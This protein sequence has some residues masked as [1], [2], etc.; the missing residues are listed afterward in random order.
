MAKREPLISSFHLQ[1]DIPLSHFGQTGFIIREKVGKKRKCLL[2]STLS[3][4]L[5]WKVQFNS[6]NVNS[7][8]SH[9][10]KCLKVT[11]LLLSICSQDSVLSTVL[12][13]SQTSQIMSRSTNAYLPQSSP[14]SLQHQMHVQQFHSNLTLHR[15]HRLRA[16]S[17][18]TAPTSD[19]S[20]KFRGSS[21][22]IGQ[23]NY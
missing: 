15:P 13:C 19:S 4:H 11:Q 14:A 7:F 18:K 17:P 2:K 6:K 22:L 5:Y 16:Q 3:K 8:I 12:Q 1:T 10:E 23:L 9:F 20:Y 21:A